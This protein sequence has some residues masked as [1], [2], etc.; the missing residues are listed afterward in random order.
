MV[1]LIINFTFSKKQ[2]WVRVV[3]LNKNGIMSYQGKCSD[4][5]A[6]PQTFLHERVPSIITIPGN[7]IH[8]Y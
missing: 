3:I 8:L 2:K 4:K 6:S 5:Q 7:L 1:R